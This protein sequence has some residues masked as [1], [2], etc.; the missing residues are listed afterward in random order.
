MLDHMKKFFMV[1]FGL[2]ALYI[3]GAFIK[4]IT[5]PVAPAVPATPTEKVLQALEGQIDFRNYGSDDSNQI[6]AF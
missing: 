6:S 2:V 5:A 3:L 1:V 4:D